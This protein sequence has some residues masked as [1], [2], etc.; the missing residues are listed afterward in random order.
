MLSRGFLSLFSVFLLSHGCQ[1][2]VSNQPAPLKYKASG[3]TPQVI[4]LYEAWFGHPRHMNVGYSSQDPAEIATQIRQAKAQGITAFVVD[5]YGDREPFIDKSYAVIQ[6]V[7]A[8]EKFQVAMMY[9]ETDQEDGATDEAIADFTM[10][11]VPTS[12]RNRQDRGLI[13]PTRAAP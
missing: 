11:H 12:Q 2:P 4:A 13:S 9:D 8:K 6:G 5:W 1:G 3:S 10:F 7:A